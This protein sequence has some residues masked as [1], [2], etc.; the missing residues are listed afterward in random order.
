LRVITYTFHDLAGGAVGGVDAFTF[1]VTLF[2]DNDAR[3][4]FCRFMVAALS[5]GLR[6]V[7]GLSTLSGNLKDW[8]KDNRDKDA[9]RVYYEVLELMER[10]AVLV[11]GAG[12]A[13]KPT[14][15][16][17][18]PV[19]S[20]MLKSLIK[21]Y[22]TNEETDE[23]NAS[24]VVYVVKD[25]SGNGKSHGGRALLQNFYALDNGKSIK[26]FMISG[27]EMDDDIPAELGRQIGAISVE[28]WIHIL[29]LAMSTPV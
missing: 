4:D 29:L 15:A 23:L 10:R 6:A 2:A 19:R 14:N 17:L 21:L 18:D 12:T 9:G 26:G 1:T 11:H 22:G 5:L 7:D 24:G 25:K 27:D 8:L 13:K 16:T 3:P 20:P 28:G